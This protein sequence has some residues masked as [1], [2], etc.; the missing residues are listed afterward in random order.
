[1]IKRNVDYTISRGFYIKNIDKYVLN[2]EILTLNK[3]I[4]RFNAG[5]ISN[6]NHLALSLIQ[7]EKKGDNDHEE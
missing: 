1:M 5:D 4:S 3:N 7:E 2:G 6:M